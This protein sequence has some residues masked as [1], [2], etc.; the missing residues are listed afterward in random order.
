MTVTK[1]AER[2]A[3]QRLQQKIPTY[4]T[5]YFTLLFLT[6]TNTACLPHK[7]LTRAMYNDRETHCEEP[8]VSGQGR[9]WRRKRLWSLLYLR[10]HS[11][12]LLWPSIARNFT[13]RCVWIPDYLCKINF[14]KVFS[15][16]ISFLATIHLV[17]VS[18]A[19]L[20]RRKA[21]NY[22]WASQVPFCIE[23]TFVNE[24]IGV[25]KLLI[26]CVT[27]SLARPTTVQ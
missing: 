27:G 14:S 4:A 1:A 24:A 21:L 5:L 10:R 13:L 23:D 19:W 3:R 6:L 16:R 17:N 20:L 12:R 15:T 11:I 2:L 22:V 8:K 9:W 18:K 26:D 7:F 25:V